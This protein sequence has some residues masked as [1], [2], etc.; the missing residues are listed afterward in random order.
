MNEE[1]WQH[2]LNTG[3]GVTVSIARTGDT[4]VDLL[5]SCADDDCAYTWTDTFDIAP[6]EADPHG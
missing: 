2:A 3:H 6:E 5:A 4:T 1:P